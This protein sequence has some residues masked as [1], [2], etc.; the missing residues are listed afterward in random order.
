MATKVLSNWH[1][2]LAGDWRVAYFNEAERD[3]VLWVYAGCCSELHTW[4]LLWSLRLRG[5]RQAARRDEQ[6]VWLTP[7]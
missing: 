4:S 6:T 5:Y 7:A 1:E 3:G 2:R